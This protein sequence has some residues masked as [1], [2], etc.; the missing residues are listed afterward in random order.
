MVGIET[1]DDPLI[2]KQPGMND[3]L[4]KPFTKE[5]LM[6]ILEKHLGHLQKGQEIVEPLSA[7]P[8]HSIAHSSTTHSLKDENSPGQSPATIS[9]WQSPPQFVGISPINPSLQA[10]YIPNIAASGGF[11]INHGALPY[12]PS[13]AD[14]TNPKPVQHRRHASEMSTIGDHSGEPKRARLL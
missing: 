11:A 14:G 7:A 10:Q 3:V 1:Q 6:N 5:G 8:T 4:P 13:H 2:A 9:T 12:Q